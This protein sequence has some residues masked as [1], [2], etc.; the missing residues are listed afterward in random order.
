MQVDQSFQ[1]FLIST[2]WPFVCVLQYWEGNT[3]F[4]SCNLGTHPLNHIL[5]PLIFILHVCIFF[6]AITLWLDIKNKYT[7]AGEI[8]Q[9]LICQLYMQ[10]FWVRHLV[11]GLDSLA[12][13]ARNPEYKER[14]KP[15]APLFHHY[16]PKANQTT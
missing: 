14:S 1:P 2:L 4:H 6:P 7:R 3:E 10:L 13:S 15:C 11:P 9:G 8:A 16:D 12:I 5:G